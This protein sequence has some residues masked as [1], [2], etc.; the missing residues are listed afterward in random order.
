M[1]IWA[2]T[3]FLDGTIGLAAGI[4]QGLYNTQDN[5][6]NTGFSSGLW[7]NPFSKAM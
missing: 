6:E 5:D 4:A 1:A 7:D 2:G 3:T